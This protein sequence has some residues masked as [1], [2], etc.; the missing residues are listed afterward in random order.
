TARAAV[1]QLESALAQRGPYGHQHA[2]QTFTAAAEELLVTLGEAADVETQEAAG[3]V[4]SA[5]CRGAAPHA[6]GGSSDTNP[7]DRDIVD[8]HALWEF[9][10]DVPADRLPSGCR[11]ALADAVKAL[12][13]FDEPRVRQVLRDLGVPE[14]KV[15]ELLGRLR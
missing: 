13:A 1:R 14:K 11:A 2:V 5:A 10:R 15:D 4:L 12:N 8:A 3:A 9:L 7:T 6:A